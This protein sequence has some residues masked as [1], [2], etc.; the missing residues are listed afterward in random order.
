MYYSHGDCNKETVTVNEIV[1]V[2]YLSLAHFDK[3]M[4]TVEEI[5]TVPL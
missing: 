4:V 5:V 2:T 1:S 3:E